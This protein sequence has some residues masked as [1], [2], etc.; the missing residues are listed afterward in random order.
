[1]DA[2]AFYKL[3]EIS[4]APDF[5]TSQ[6]QYTGAEKMKNTIGHALLRPLCIPAFY[7]PITA[8]RLQVKAVRLIQNEADAGGVFIEAEGSCVKLCAH[9]APNQRCNT[10]AD[11]QKQSVSAQIFLLVLF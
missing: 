8:A 4:A 11:D 1:M 10:Q 3:A 7:Q 2:Q 5:A 9:G 6:R